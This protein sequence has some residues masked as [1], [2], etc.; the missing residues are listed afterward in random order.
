LVIKKKQSANFRV[1]VATR[2]TPSSTGFFYEM[3][4]EH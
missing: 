1:S 3:K 4:P 2:P